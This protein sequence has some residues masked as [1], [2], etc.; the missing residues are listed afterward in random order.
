MLIQPFYARVLTKRELLKHPAYG[1]TD[2][3]GF[4]D[5]IN[6]H[7]LNVVSAAAQYEAE[8]Q[9]SKNLRPLCG[10]IYLKLFIDMLVPLVV[11]IRGLIELPIVVLSVSD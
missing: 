5:P 7:D 3:E 8:W 10:M 1:V 6:H 11:G 9:Y 4:H 2:W